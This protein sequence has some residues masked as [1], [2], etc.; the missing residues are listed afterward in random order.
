MPVDPSGLVR[1]EA[2]RRVVEQTLLDRRPAAVAI[3]GDG[4]GGDEEGEEGETE[5]GDGP[6]IAERPAPPG[7]QEIEDRRP[8]TEAE[9]YHSLGE[10]GQGERQG[11]EEDRPPPLVWRARLGEL[12]ETEMDPGDEEGECGVDDHPAGLLDEED[13]RG[14]DERGEERR[15][16]SEAPAEGP[17]SEERQ[18][19]EEGRGEARRGG[20]DPEGPEREDLHPPVEG[21][22]LQEG[23]TVQ[24]RHDEVAGREHRPAHGGAGRLVRAPQRAP[25]PG[26]AEEES[27]DE[28]GDQRGTKLRGAGDR[29]RGFGH[30]GQSSMGSQED[31][32]LTAARPSL[33]LATAPRTRPYSWSP[34]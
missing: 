30:G 21:G 20:G 11:D 28:A 31:C 1:E 17:G 34:S 24:A 32:R 8:R 33:S 6:E 4:P 15:P 14:E 18:R 29:S 3:E 26:E 12:R 10:E 22:L 19:S 16:G 9:R 27:E 25:E 23:L 13:G 5:S 2:P 7:G